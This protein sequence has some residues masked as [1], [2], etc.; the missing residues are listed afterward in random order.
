M[1]LSLPV[2]V[3]CKGDCFAGSVPAQIAISYRR[4]RV[5]QKI[6]DHCEARSVTLEADRICVAKA[7]CMDSFVDAGPS[8]KARQQMS[9]IAAVE[10]LSG[11]C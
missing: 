2:P 9:D 11:E 10:L 8:C 1:R 5:S 3:A 4:R 7:V 6:S